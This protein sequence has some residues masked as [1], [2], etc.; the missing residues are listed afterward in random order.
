MLSTRPLLIALL[1]LSLSSARWGAAA[2]YMPPEFDL[3]AVPGDT[4]DRPH[5]VTNYEGRAVLGYLADGDDDNEHL[6]FDSLSVER[7]T[8][9]PLAEGFN[10][11]AG[12]V[13]VRVP[14]VD[15]RNEYIVVLFGDSGNRSPEFN[16]VN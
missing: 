6:E 10:L 13:T 11:T 15:P 4:S 7:M 1:A 3:G 9:H 2:F 16:I 5:E 12:H 14:D 8:E